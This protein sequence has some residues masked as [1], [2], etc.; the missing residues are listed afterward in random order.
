MSEQSSCCKDVSKKVRSFDTSLR[1]KYNAGDNI[2]HNGQHAIR[3]WLNENGYA[4]RIVKGRIEVLT[5]ANKVVIIKTMR[6][7]IEHVI[8]EEKA[9]ENE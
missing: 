4:S 3:T 7:A 5:K 2:M 8:K 6:D 9:N 1:V